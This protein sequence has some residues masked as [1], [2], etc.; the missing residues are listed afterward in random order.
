[1]TKSRVT[2]T[3]V[4]R[5]AG[6]SKMTVSRVINNKAEISEATR[7]HVFQAM[8][9]L[10]YRPNPIARSLAT[11]TTS[12][13]GIMVP[14]LSNDYFGAIIEGVENVLWDNGYHILLGNS[15]GNLQRERAI[16]EAF[17]DHRADGVIVLSAQYDEGSLNDYLR[18]QRAAVTIN[19]PV[20][21]GLAVCM[22]TDE[23]KSMALAV[24]HLLSLGRTHLG[25]VHFN[26]DTY[27]ST[28]RYRGFEL[29]VKNAGMTFDAAR[30]TR[31]TLARDPHMMQNIME[32]LQHNSRIDGLIC[33][34]SGIAARALLACHKL[35]RRVPDDIAVMGYDD[36]FLAELTTPPLTTLDLAYPKYEVGAMA[37]RL[38]LGCIE[39]TETVQDAVIL[40]HKLVV[41][42][43]AP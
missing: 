24:H 29:A 7:Q 6:V 19:A 22:Y 14:S 21:S 37:A 2:I 5:R 42:E 38:L 25:Y 43:S 35:G 13:I 16:M 17:E 8:E 28:E 34:N 33:F 1:M 4:A 10:G 15:G 36:N 27:A 26:N 3:D 18:N 9:E 39:D 41:R 12:R 23:I 32:L 31:Q 20:N 30:Q 40:E 11:N